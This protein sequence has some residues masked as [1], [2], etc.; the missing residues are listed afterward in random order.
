MRHDK[1][2]SYDLTD[3]ELRKLTSNSI[4]EVPVQNRIDLIN[5]VIKND[6]QDK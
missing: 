4:K 6:F 5:N 1:T 3:E 2:L